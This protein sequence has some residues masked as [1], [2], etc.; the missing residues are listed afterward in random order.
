MLNSKVINLNFKQKYLIFS[1]QGQILIFFSN[2][3]KFMVYLWYNL[4][5]RVTL[6]FLIYRNEIH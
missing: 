1:M 4:Y 5:T 6:S 3:A 2:L